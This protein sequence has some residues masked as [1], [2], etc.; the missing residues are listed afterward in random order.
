[1]SENTNKSLKLLFFVD[2]GVPQ[3]T[4]LGPSQFIVYIN[5]NKI[6]WFIIQRIRIYGSSRYIDNSARRMVGNF[7]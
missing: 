7:Y 1:M 6:F 5:D 4:L 2:N 3:E